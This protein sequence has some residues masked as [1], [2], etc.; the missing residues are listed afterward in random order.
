MLLLWLAT[1]AAL[2][3]QVMFEPVQIAEAVERARVIAIVVPDTPPIRT[4]SVAV[5]IDRPDPTRCPPFVRAAERWV[6]E[7][8]VYDPDA[9]VRVGVHLEVYSPTDEVLATGH[10]LY[11]Y[12]GVMESPVV[13]RYE[14]LAAA[15]GSEA[16]R[17]VFLTRSAFRGGPLEWHY[18]ASGA[19]DGPGSLD[20]VQELVAQRPERRSTVRE[21]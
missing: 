5:C 3:S 19:V 11:H 10:E 8:V 13:Q 20:T 6:V 7:E 14:P 21:P 17:I 18:V 1:V 9:A 15:S 16:R 12:D 4:T 2:A